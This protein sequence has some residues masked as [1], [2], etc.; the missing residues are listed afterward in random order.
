MKTAT[1]ESKYKM[2]QKMATKYNKLSNNCT[3]CKTA[4]KKKACS[5]DEYIEYS[6]AT[7]VKCEI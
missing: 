1:P 3:L 6:G 5:V 7:I 2:A 4:T